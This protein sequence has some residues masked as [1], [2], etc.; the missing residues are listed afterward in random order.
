MDNLILVTVDRQTVEGSAFI[1]E[2]I[3]QSFQTA[4][5]SLYE[6][7]ELDKCQQVLADR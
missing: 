1:R 3:G 7:N 5:L 6:G 4:S 2:E